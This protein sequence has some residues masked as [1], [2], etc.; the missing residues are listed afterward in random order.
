[1][2]ALPRAQTHIFW[3]IDG[4]VQYK[5]SVAPFRREV[6]LALRVDVFIRHQAVPKFKEEFGQ[7]IDVGIRI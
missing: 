3:K 7:E 6:R 1:M 5:P 2:R 4:A